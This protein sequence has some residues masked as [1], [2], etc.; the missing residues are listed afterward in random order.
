[1]YED[2]IVLTDILSAAF[3]K[4]AMDITGPLTPMKAGRTYIL[5][6]QDLLT[7]FFIAISLQ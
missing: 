5:T 2:T 4:V 3:D 7:K 6:I 1:M